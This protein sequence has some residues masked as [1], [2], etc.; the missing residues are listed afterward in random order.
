VSPNWLR[1]RFGGRDSCWMLP[2]AGMVYY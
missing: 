2:A 1:L